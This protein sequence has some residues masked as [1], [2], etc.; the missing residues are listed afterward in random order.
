MERKIKT[1]LLSLLTPGLGY[2]QYGDRKSF[3]KTILLFVSVL[4]VS[5]SFRLFTSFWGLAASLFSLVAIHVSAAIHATIKTKTVCGE[6]KVPG[7]LK[8]CFTVAFLLTTGLL[9]A[10]RRIIM[11]FDIM[12]MDVPVME[13]TLLQ[14]ERFLVNTWA[15]ESGLKRGDIVVHSFRGQ[16]GLYLNRI[17]GIGGETIEI[18]DGNVLVNGKILNE[19]YVLTANVTKPQSRN[20]PATIV[21][22]GQFFVMGDNRDASFGDSRFNGTIAIGTII[23]EATDIISSQDNLRVGTTL[24]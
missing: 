5:A 12:S 17:I 9:F 11:G 20:L 10:N 7:L 13:P 16:K 6:A 18:K 15:A 21:P 22:H 19:P 8:A 3:Y 2:L 23:S 14:G 1:L 4:F 24:R